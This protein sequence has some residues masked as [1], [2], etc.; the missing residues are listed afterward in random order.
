M[1]KQIPI[2]QLKTGMFL[3]D[4]DL[5]LSLFPG[6]KTQT[7]IS[8][9]H[10]LQNIVDTG[11]QE[12]TI[13]TIKGNDVDE[14]ALQALKHQIIITHGS[15]KRQP[16]PAPALPKLESRS[17]EE[18]IKT[19]KSLK[20][21]TME[22]VNNAFADIKMGRKINTHEIKTSVKRMTD[23]IIRNQDALLALGQIRQK[24]NYSF[25]HAINTCILAL[26]FGKWQKLDHETIINLGTAALLHDIGET[27]LD[28]KLINLKGNLN[29]QEFAEVQKHVDY[30]VQLLST[31]PGIHPQIVT[32]VQQH[33]E[34]LDGSGYP[35]GLQGSEIDPLSQVLG[36]IDIYD[37]MT[38]ETL[39][40]YSTAPTHVLKQLLESENELFDSLLIKQFIKCIGIYPVGSLVKL[41]NGCI[42]I[43]NEIF[44]HD[45]LHPKVKVIYNARQE[46]FIQPIDLNLS[47]L[48]YSEE[49]ISI[50]GSVDPNLLHID[51]AAFI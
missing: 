16:I 40:S 21:H 42:A 47:E 30:S 6:I 37:S 50:K 12:V 18:E 44:N 48:L 43:V 32:L 10:L 8:N 7:S 28:D 19:A 15:K 27:K 22:A 51:L 20:R 17:F 45:S 46:H 5:K 25:D 34:R 2:S 24:S 3:H 23:S 31:N 11:I 38:A 4:L 39:Y 35:N 29:E 9:R 36:L 33:H 1:L 41:S 14:P 13:D 49:S 26:S